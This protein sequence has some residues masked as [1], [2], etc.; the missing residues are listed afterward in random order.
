MVILAERSTFAKVISSVWNEAVDKAAHLGALEL[1]E[2]DPGVVAAL[3]EAGATLARSRIMDELIDQCVTDL[4]GPQG[5]LWPDARAMTAVADGLG[6]Q[7]RCEVMSEL[8]DAAVAELADSGEAELLM[9][10]AAAAPSRRQE[11]GAGADTDENTWWDGDN[12]LPGADGALV[13]PGIGAVPAFETREGATGASATTSL[14]SASSTSALVGVAETHQAGGSGEDG[15]ERTIHSEEARQ[16][17]GKW[18]GDGRGAMTETEAAILMQSVL[19]RKA[20]YRD[21]K[22]LVARNFVRL[23]DPNHGAFYW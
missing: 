4:T 21:T 1:R 2:I 5:E 22:A 16:S 7:V 10:E 20:V 6:Y 19:R 14:S 15:V 9:S 23:Y 8:I 17:D 13:D 11:S 12:V 18:G 3:S